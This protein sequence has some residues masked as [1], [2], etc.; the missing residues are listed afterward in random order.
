[1]PLVFCLEYVEKILITQKCRRGRA[2]TGKIRLA[3]LVI[4][5]VWA[6][7]L[8]NISLVSRIW[9]LGIGEKGWS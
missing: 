7:L 3:N 5:C 6:Y 1:M 4:H 9:G 8:G 2:L